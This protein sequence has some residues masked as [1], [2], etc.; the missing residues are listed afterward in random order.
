MFDAD[1][2]P[3][4][5]IGLS[6]DISERKRAEEATARAASALAEAQQIAGVGSFH[7]DTAR[8]EVEWSDELRRM[9][10]IPA[11]SEP[12]GPETLE[13]VHGDDRIADRGGG[14]RPRCAQRRD[15]RARP[16]DA[17][18]RRRGAA[19]R[20]RAGATLAP[21]GT[22]RRLDGICEDVTE[23]RRAESHLAEAQR[24]AQIGSFDRDLEHDEV[25]WSPETYRIFGVDPEHL[26]PSREN[27]LSMVVE[28]DRKRL[29]G[30]VDR[31]IR[32]DGAFDAL[33]AIR[34][35]DGEPRDLRV[36]GA[37]HRVG[38]GPRHL[39]GIVQDVTD[40][41]GATAS[42]RPPTAC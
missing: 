2:R 42:G 16:A 38:S 22:P 24:L 11:G 19:D 8:R 25:R 34:R 23:R 39:I 13:L 10:A 17:P 32:E 1:G 5:V 26:V 20:V 21:D 9:L 15:V 33:V 41:L 18:R 37:V 29:R 27:V 12:L 6:T 36:R 31:A 7:W 4:A 30:E 28:G 3:V 14:A 35:A 40:V